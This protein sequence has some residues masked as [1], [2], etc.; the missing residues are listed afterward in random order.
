MVLVAAIA[1]GVLINTA[2]FLQSK[3]QQTGEE[4]SAQVTNQLQ[5]VSE[6]GI[7]NNGDQSSADLVVLN[8]DVPVDSGDVVNIDVTTTTDGHERS[9]ELSTGGSSGGVVVGDG[10]TGGTETD[11]VAVKFEVV[12]GD[13]VLLTNTETGASLQFDPSSQDLDVTPTDSQSGQ[14]SGIDYQ[15]TDSEF[16]DT[17][18]SASG[19]PLSGADALTVSATTRTEQFAQIEG[20]SGTNLLVNSSETVTV[21]SST[22]GDLIAGGETLSISSGDELKFTFPS[23]AEIKIKNLATSASVVF[24]GNTDTLEAT[25]SNTVALKTDGSTA[26]VTSGGSFVKT[27]SRF[28]FA[29]S[30]ADGN[31]VTQVDLLVASSAGAGDIDLTQTVISARTPKGSFTLNYGQTTVEN[32]QFTITAVQDEDDTAPVLTSGDRFE[33]NLDL[34]TLEGGDTVELRI[35]TGSGATKV[36]QLRVPNSLANKEAVGL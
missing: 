33:L 36:V 26:S 27:S 30:L 23:A 18:V 11:T 10:V 15:F 8:G 35:T 21:G 9:V 24:N 6:T 25:S 17:T 28:L 16:G 3:S 20:G 34:G 7:V 32:E 5:V 19:T 12:S 1:A 2:G 13:E 31:A 29:R 22:D 14:I 4:S